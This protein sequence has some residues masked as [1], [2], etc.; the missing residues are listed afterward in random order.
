MLATLPGT[1]NGHIFIPCYADDP[2]VV[3]LPSGIRGPDGLAFD[4]RCGRASPNRGGGFTPVDVDTPTLDTCRIGFTFK[5][6]LTCFGKCARAGKK[7]T[8]KYRLVKGKY[9]FGC[10]C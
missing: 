9:T 5:G 1:G 7:C 10:W 8:L 4:C 6:V 3:C 2:D